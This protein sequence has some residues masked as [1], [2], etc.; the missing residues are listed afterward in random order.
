MIEQSF[1]K[2]DRSSHCHCV[3]LVSHPFMTMKFVCATLAW[4]R[5]I[6]Q[7]R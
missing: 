2:T 5:S 3:G 7:V 6:E 4:I 1:D